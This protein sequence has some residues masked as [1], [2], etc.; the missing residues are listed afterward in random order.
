MVKYKRLNSADGESEREI[1]ERTQ[2]K[3]GQA[4]PFMPAN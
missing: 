4:R 1:F 2:K 3:D